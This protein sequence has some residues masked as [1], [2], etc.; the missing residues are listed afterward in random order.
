MRISLATPQDLPAVVALYDRVSVAMEGSPYSA[1]WAQGIYP[2][3]SDIR[4]LVNDGCQWAGWEDS[5]LVASYALDHNLGEYASY[6]WPTAVAPQDALV[7]H[8]L[9]TD[10]AHRG[11][12]LAKQLIEHAIELVRADHASVIRLDVIAQNLPAI[13]LYESYG[14]RR[15]GSVHT[16]Y[17]DIGQLDFLLYELKL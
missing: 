13:H 12:G 15:A 14:F 1:H 9:C 8:L 7:I 16:C 4:A 3:E 5:V 17:E 10:P 11:S 6:A 2:A